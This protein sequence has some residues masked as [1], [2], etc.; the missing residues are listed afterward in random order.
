MPVIT[1]ASDGSIAVKEVAAIPVNT[2]ETPEWGKR[3]S[4][5]YFFTVGGD[6]VITPP[7]SAP[8]VRTGG[9]EIKP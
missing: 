8:P 9:A 6:F 2:R 3:V 4:P 1:D 7:R 5:R